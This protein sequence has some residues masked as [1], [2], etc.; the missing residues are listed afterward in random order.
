[1]FPAEAALMSA[2]LDPKNFSIEVADV[3]LNFDFPFYSGWL[4]CICFTIILMTVRA[5]KVIKFKRT[6]RYTFEV[7]KT[8]VDQEDITV[9]STRLRIVWLM[10]NITA[11]VL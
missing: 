11:L 8:L 9:K 2:H 7:F 3:F 1:M 6:M 4:V 10:F 5:R